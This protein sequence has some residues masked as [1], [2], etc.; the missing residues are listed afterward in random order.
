MLLGIEHGLAEGRLKGLR[1]GLQLLKIVPFPLLKAELSG[2]LGTFLLV[3]PVE[4]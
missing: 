2:V 4:V 3:A 1:S